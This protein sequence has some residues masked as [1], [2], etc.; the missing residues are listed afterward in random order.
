MLSEIAPMTRISVSKRTTLLEVGDRVVT[1]LAE[2]LQAFEHG[3]GITAIADRFDVMHN[4]TFCRTELYRKPAFQGL[5][6]CFPDVPHP[7]GPAPIR[8]EGA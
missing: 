4:R 3:I 1:R 5:F 6:D 8:D 2:R 7:G